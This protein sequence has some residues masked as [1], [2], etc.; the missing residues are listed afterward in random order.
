MIKH[1][2]FLT[3]PLYLFFIHACAIANDQLETVIYLLRHGQTD[4]NISEILQSRLDVSLNDQGRQEAARAGFLL[5]NEHFDICYSSPM[6]RAI[7]TASIIIYPRDLPIL[8]DERII[9]RYTG[10]WEGRLKSD[11]LSATP[12][13]LE[14]VET[15]EAMIERIFLFLNELL[16]KH[17]GKKILIISH[18]DVLG[19]I[20]RKFENRSAEERISI[21]NCGL[22]KLRETNGIWSLEKELE[23][24]LPSPPLI[25]G[26]KEKR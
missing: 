25:G 12:E 10:S 2:L 23:W 1:F 19:N 18:T 22:I 5:Q 11:Y 17:T 8:T 7:E 6:I 13:E 4:S 9:E 15:N 3:I 16:N 21:P 20:I 26:V 14:D 24:I